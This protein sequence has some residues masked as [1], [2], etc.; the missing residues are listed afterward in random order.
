MNSARRA[1][2]GELSHP[3]ALAAIALLA[4]N[5]H[6]LKGAGLLPAWLTGKLSDVAGLY[7]FPLL[8]FALGSAIASVLG[9]GSRRWRVQLARLAPAAT[10]LGF[11]GVKLDPAFNAW[12]SSWW[13]PM[14]LDPTDLLALVALVPAGR[15]L[16]RAA[17]RAAATPEPPRWLRSLA[18]VSA[19]LACVATPRPMMRRNYPMWEL[20]AAR[21][22]VGCMNVAAWVSKSG[23]QG[24]GVTLELA[25]QGEACELAILGAEV[26]LRDG[27]R[28]RA[29]QLPG[30]L[31]L[32]GEGH[33]Y[34]PFEFDNER[35]WN[36]GKRHATL[37]LELSAGGERARWVVPMEHVRHAPH[38]RDR[39]IEPQRDAGSSQPALVPRETDPGL[40]EFAQ[41][42]EQAP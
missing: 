31:R 13:G 3:L 39:P 29:A 34:L 12:V 28:V 20:E 41:P 40:P 22:V 24:L 7:L 37:R 6:V 30:P 2:P 36:D 14:V 16:R 26:Q 1:V 18:L 21:R 15:H 23:K 42:P 33:V 17:E 10:G 35:A 38:V 32:T 27:D 25:P 9:V 19:A 8:L 4:L 5:D 11:V